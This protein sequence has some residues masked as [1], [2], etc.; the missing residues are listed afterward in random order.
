MKIHR[1]LGA[2]LVGLRVVHTFPG[3]RVSR[4]VKDI[5][6]RGASKIDIPDVLRDR[7]VHVFDGE[8]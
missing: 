6:E 5:V 7:G 4:E 1:R 3:E 2:E 8:C